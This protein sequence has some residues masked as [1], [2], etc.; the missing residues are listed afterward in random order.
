MKTIANLPIFFFFIL[1][2]NFHYF[3]YCVVIYTC[4]LYNSAIYIKIAAILKSVLQDIDEIL[5]RTLKQ[6]CSVQPKY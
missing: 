2:S 5:E 1:L 6:Y 4:I 3:Q